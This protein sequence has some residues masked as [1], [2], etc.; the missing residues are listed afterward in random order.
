MS[1]WWLLVP[2][3]CGLLTLIAL[4]AVARLFRR[5][6]RLRNQHAA[7]WVAAVDARDFTAAERCLTAYFSVRASWLS[8]PVGVPGTRPSA[9]RDREPPGRWTAR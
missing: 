8:A 1:M 5:Q 4:T 6:E 2:G 7:A 9:D 3:G